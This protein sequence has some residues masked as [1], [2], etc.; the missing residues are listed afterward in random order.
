MDLSNDNDLTYVKGRGGKAQ[1]QI[2]FIKGKVLG[3]NCNPQIGVTVLIWQASA[4]GRYNHKRDEDNLIFRH[5]ISGK[6]IERSLDPHF[7]YWG[8]A[9]TNS[10]GEYMFKTV[11][12]GFYPANLREGWYRPPHIHFQVLRENQPPFT[13]QMYFKG[14]VL[15]DHDLIQELNERDFLLQSS[16]VSREQRR[17]LVIDFNEKMV[18]EFNI[19]I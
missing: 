1:G 3:Q 17:Q 16:E 4:S 2:V 14:E 13:T 10:R 5:P 18:G 8:K 12:P 6:V 19:K 11:L 7:Q 9:I 15:K